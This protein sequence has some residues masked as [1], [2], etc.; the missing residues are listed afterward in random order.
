MRC[1]RLANRARAAAQR[2]RET[3]HSYRTAHML[4]VFQLP[5]LNFTAMIS[6]SMPT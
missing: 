4:I 5:L 3:H 2:R 6:V 1:V